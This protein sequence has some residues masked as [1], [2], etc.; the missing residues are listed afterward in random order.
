MT[1]PTAK[2]QKIHPRYAISVTGCPSTVYNVNGRDEKDVYARL[3]G[4]QTLLDELPRQ[5]DSCLDAVRPLKPRGWYGTS[6]DWA[7]GEA[8]DST[9]Q[10]YTVC[11][12]QEG[13]STRDFAA[14]EDVGS[15][16][17]VDEDE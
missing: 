1:R 7:A 5:C 15:D 10:R 14:V 2:E 16:M 4:A 12:L 11:D 17:D 9:I 6:F 13:V 3:L 8:N